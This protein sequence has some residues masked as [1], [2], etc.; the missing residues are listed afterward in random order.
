MRLPG[1]KTMRGA[2]NC[3]HSR[4]AN[5]VLILGYHRVAETAVDP[6]NLCVR[7]D[8]FAQQMD[9]LRRQAQVIDIQT[10]ADG[11]QNGSLP[12][13][14]VVITFD[15]GYLDILQT[16][17]PLLVAKDLPATVF[18]V[19]GALGE[20]FWWGSLSRIIFGPAVLPNSLTLP[21][22][23]QTLTGSMI[24]TDQAIGIKEAPSPRRRLLDQ[25]FRR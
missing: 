8:H 6:D 13:R 17:K 21:I 10:L 15:D 7:P 16:A 11:L 18:A 9:V 5:F 25:L 24:D 1:L 23:G 3:L 20:E 19:T 12:R 4:L 14:A 2:A 22:C